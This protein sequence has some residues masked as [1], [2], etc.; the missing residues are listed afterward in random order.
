VTL[1]ETKAAG[2]AHQAGFHMHAAELFSQP[3]HR[4]HHA[5]ATSG[6]CTSIYPPLLLRRV[7]DPRPACSDS[8]SY[9][10]LSVR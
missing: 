9:T 6:L 4:Q 7:A 2:A 5:V 8:L 10:S 1:I 3:N